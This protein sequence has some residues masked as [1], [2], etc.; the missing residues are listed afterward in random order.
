M[1]EKKEPHDQEKQNYDLHIVVK[2][3][4]FDRQSITRQWYVVIA[5]CN[6]GGRT[7]YL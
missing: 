5:A 2:V 3:L 6:N 4:T 1:Q 7:R